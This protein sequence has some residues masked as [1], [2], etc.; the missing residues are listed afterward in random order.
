[1]ADEEQ[2]C[3]EA[4]KV[5][6]VDDAFRQ[7]DLDALRAAVD[8]PDAIPNGRMPDAIGPCLTYAIYRS[9]LAFIRTLLELGADPNRR[10]WVSAA[11]R[12]AEF[13]A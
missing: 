4:R 11:H 10:R 1:M 12:R 7:G 2:R 3:A 8:D 6:R 9:P 5:R 13:R